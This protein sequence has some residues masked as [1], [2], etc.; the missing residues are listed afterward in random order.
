[1]N[2]TTIVSVV[3]LVVVIIVI[4]GLVFWLYKKQRSEKLRQRFGPEYDR[5]V[6]EAG[7]RREAES[8]LK[9]RERRREQLDLHSLPSETR[10]RFRDEWNGIQ[11]RF[12]DVPGQAVQDAD[13]LVARI[14]REIGYPMDDFEQ[15]AADISVE[16]PRVVQHYRAAHSTAIEHQRGHAETE[17]L[18]QSVTSYRVLVDVLLEDESDGTVEGKTRT[19]PEDG[20]GSS[21]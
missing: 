9:D 15:R 3:V 8:E 12:V 17:Q 20:A 4:A 16:H 2:M 5:T 13:E 10:D 1:M 18:R 11:Q 14:M 21:N 6:S 7:D 19:P